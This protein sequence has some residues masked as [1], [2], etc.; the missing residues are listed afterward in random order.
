MKYYFITTIFMFGAGSSY[1][2]TFQEAIESIS[3]HASVQAIEQKSNAT[4]Q[5]GKNMSAWGDPM[6]KVTAKNFPIES[7]SF[8]QTPMTGI[9]F[10]IAQNIPITNKFG[11]IQDAYNQLALATQ[12]QSQ[13][14]KRELIRSLWLILIENQ[15]IDEEIKIVEENLQWIDNIVLISQ[16][17]YANG[18][19]SQQALLDI[20]I[21]QSELDAQLSNKRFTLKE[22]VDL[23]GYLLGFDHSSID[24]DSIPWSVLDQ[25]DENLNDAKVKSMQHMVAS[26]ESALIAKKRDLVPDVTLSLGYTLRSDVDQNGDFVSA[27]IGFPFPVSGKKTA[28]RIKAMHEKV[29]AEKNLED[30]NIFKE[31]RLRQQKNRIEMINQELV[32]LNERTI[33]FAKNSREI[34][35]K[36]YSH[37]TST[38]IELLQSEL[39]LQELLL[40][41]SQL[42]AELRATKVAYKYLSGGNLHV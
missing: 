3:K 1:A 16:R 38:Y 40:Q 41:Q 8:D 21:R 17:L 22:Q 10:G 36:S 24:K 27:T 7:L 14:K 31:S 2:F 9:E 37:G 18:S 23:L 30:Y 25:A 13:D 35:S 34:T 11:K 4:E 6:L 32:I 28:S 5:E 20:K 19:I 29:S 15:K 39:K 42:E 12:Y 26:K 33:E